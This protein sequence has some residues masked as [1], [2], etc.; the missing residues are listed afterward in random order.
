VIRREGGLSTR[1]LYVPRRRN[2]A[3]GLRQ[4]G[5]GDA[6]ELGV[7]VGEL[8]NLENGAKGF[9]EVARNTGRKSVKLRW[10]QSQKSETLVI[11]MQLRPR[12]K[13]RGR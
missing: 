5:K 9:R 13:K 6:R 4:I 8:L 7:G 2:P 11:S 10:G 12:K 3:S 1:A